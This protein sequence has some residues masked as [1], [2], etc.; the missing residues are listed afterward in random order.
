[1]PILRQLAWT[2][3]KKAASN[4]HVQQKAVDAVKVVDKKMDLAAEKAVRNIDKSSVA[5]EF[6]EKTDQKI[7]A[8]AERVGQIAASDDPAKEIGRAFGKLFSKK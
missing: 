5:G 3:L 7:D 8:A 4:P 6:I 2:A 1:M